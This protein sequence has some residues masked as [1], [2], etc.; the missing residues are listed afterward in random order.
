MTV[1]LITDS[2]WPSIVNIQAQVYGKEFLE[3]LNVLQ[4]KWQQSPDCC[5]VF[6][7]EHGEIEAYLLGH[8]W[9]QL[10]P[11]KLNQL[12]PDNSIGEYVFLHDLAVVEPGKGIATQMLKQFLRTAAIYQSSKVMLVS[13]QS[14]KAFWLKQG[15]NLSEKCLDSSYGKNAYLMER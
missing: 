3:S 4:S 1:R 9:N 15:F 2:D 14:S 11:P 5:Y 6:E 12:L 7:N 8:R 10:T 13:V